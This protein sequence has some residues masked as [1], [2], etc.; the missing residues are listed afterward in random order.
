MRRPV[1]K[2]A[3]R[4]LEVLELFN[5]QRRPLKLQEIYEL[6]GYPQS[7]ATHLMKTLVQLGYINYN[8][9]TRVYVPSCRVRGLGTWMTSAMYGQQ[10]YHRLVEALQQRTDETVALSMQNDLFIQYFIIKTPNHEYKAPPTEGNMRLIPDSTSG[11]ALLSRMSDRQVDKIC[12]NINYYES[13]AGYR[14]DTAVVMK[15]LAWVRHVGYCYR[16]NAP[17]AGVSSIAFSLDETM[18]GVPLALGVGGTTERLGTNK[19]EITK[20]IRATIAEF[21][22]EWRDESGFRMPQPDANQNDRFEVQRAA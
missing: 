2:S 9:A 7:S 20:A 21:S 13:S 16:E 1:V 5:E 3:S 18:Y 17:A 6:L 12:R 4:A 15:E 14:V 19:S 8:R 10:R 11:M 22:A